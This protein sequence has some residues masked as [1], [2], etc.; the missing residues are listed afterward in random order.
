[1]YNPDVI[2]FMKTHTHAHTECSCG[3]Y[4]TCTHSPWEKKMSQ[5]KG[6]ACF[7][8]DRLVCRPSFICLNP[9][10]KSRVQSCGGVFFSCVHVCVFNYGHENIKVLKCLCI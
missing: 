8:S 2:A 10:G 9:L 3:M 5:R 1:M 6:S 4:S 7:H